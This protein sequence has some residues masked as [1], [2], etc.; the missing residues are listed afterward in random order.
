[1]K[2]GEQ[3]YSCFLINSLLGT[4]PVPAHGRRGPWCPCRSE[5]RKQR[6]LQ[7]RLPLLLPGVLACPDKRQVPL[8]G[9]HRRRDLQDH[10]TW[11]EQPQDMN[12]PPV[13]LLSGV[14]CSASSR[15]Q[16]G[17]PSFSSVSTRHRRLPQYP[18]PV[19]TSRWWCQRKRGGERPVQP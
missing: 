9:Q 6:Q 3:R 13:W 1:M 12:R 11:A 16:Q 10:D 2:L 4:Q 14:L 8:D 17:T 19:P 18:E 15:R 7:G 5:R